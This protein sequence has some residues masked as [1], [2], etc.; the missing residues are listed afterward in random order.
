M[1]SS[2]ELRSMPRRVTPATL[3]SESSPQI[4]SFGLCRLTTTT[5]CG[6]IIRLRQLP[7][8][9]YPIFVPR[10]SARAQ[11]DHIGH[12]VRLKLS[13]HSAPRATAP[14]SP[15]ERPPDSAPALLLSATSPEQSHQLPP[16]R[17]R[18]FSQH[19]G[20]S[21]EACTSS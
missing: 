14:A 4:R 20:P 9:C 6:S 16:S 5:E 8:R 18:S 1:K 13:S 2:N 15:S 17:S 12:S 21:E 11:K 3:I 19:R 10:A 7:V